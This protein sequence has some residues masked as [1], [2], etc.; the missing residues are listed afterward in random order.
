M[1]EPMTPTQFAEL[2][3]ELQRQ[4]R[5]LGAWFAR[6]HTPAGRCGAPLDYGTFFP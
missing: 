6:G 3:E 4:A 5:E 1:N 2:K